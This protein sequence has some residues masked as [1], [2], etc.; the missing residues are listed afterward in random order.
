MTGGRAGI[1]TNAWL[2]ALLAIALCACAERAEKKVEE[3]IYP[4]G[5]KASILERISVQLADPIAIRDAYI[6]EPA[7]KTQG[8]YTR[9]IACLRFNAKGSDGQY[10]G[11]KDMAAFFFNGKLTQIVDADRD[12]CGTAAYLPFPELQKL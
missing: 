1:R 5:Y 12:L 10:A 6:A 8:A 3:N 9:Y 7:L 11:S 4:T 2:V